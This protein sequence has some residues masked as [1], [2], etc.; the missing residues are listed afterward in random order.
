MYLDILAWIYDLSDIDFH[1]VLAPL[2][3]NVKLKNYQTPVHVGW[4]IM[5]EISGKLYFFPTN[6]LI[7]DQILQHTVLQCM[8]ENTTH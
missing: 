4:I 1:Y 5:F 2:T 7:Q 8:Y 3:S 6:Y